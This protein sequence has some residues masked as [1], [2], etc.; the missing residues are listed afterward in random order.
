MP[1]SFRFSLSSQ[2]F[3]APFI[4][5]LAETNRFRP[6]RKANPYRRMAKS[7]KTNHVAPNL[8]NREFE[9]HEPRVVLLTDITYLH[10]QDGFLYLSTII[11]AF[12]K[13]ALAHVLS[14]SL[15]IDFVLKTVQ[16]MQQ[17][18]RVSLEVETLI[19][20]DYAEEKTVQCKSLGEN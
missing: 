4:P 7:L 11:D 16:I 15:E 17:N 8:L 18:Y 5:F 2:K 14:A 20:F 19:H 10:F 1:L 12:I 9:T 3:I 6:I 13:E